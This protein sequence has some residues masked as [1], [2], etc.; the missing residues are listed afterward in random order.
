VSRS[1]DLS[2]IHEAL[3]ASREILSAFTPGSVDS[4][5]KPGH[6]PVTEADLQV[7]AKLR[8][9]L[10]RDGEAWLS[11]ETADDH[12]R[13]SARRVWI[14]D[15]IDGTKEFVRGRPEWCVSVGLIEDGRA[16]A[17]GILNPETD[18]LVLGALETGVTLNGEPVHL[19]EC[20]Q[21]EGA[22][23]LASRSEIRRGE[24]EDY[25]GAGLVIEPLGSVAWKMAK[26]AAG[27]ADATW[28]LKPKNEWDVAA[29]A[30]LIA[31]GGGVCFL[32]DGSEMTFNRPDPLLKGLAGTAEGLR[33][34]VG[35]LLRERF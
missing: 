26:V 3:E 12:V 18:E 7:D 4:E 29:G 2:R 35:E 23:V 8:E 28:T 16:V 1:E 19:R 34:P 6:G 11:E 30:A 17:G 9:M 5:H 21:L 31:A 15:P 14:V 33:R 20:S 24:W 22:V 10:P 13:L 25:D 32:P 27:K